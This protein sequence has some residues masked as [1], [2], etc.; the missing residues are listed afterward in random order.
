[1]ETSPL[2]IQNNGRYQKT[3]IKENVTQMLTML[4]FIDTDIYIDTAMSNDG[5]DDVV[6]CRS[7]IM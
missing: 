3:D 1:M 2:M 5:V 6:A 7:S 4:P